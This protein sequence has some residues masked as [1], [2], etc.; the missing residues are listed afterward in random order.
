MM[1][2][3]ANEPLNDRM[4]ENVSKKLVTGTKRWAGSGNAL[5]NAACAPAMAPRTSRSA[6]LGYMLKG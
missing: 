6:L 1:A 3:H 5:W 4:A 2:M